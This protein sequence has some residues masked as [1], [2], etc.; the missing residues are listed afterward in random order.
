MSKYASLDAVR[1]DVEG[2]V[3]GEHGLASLKNTLQQR[4]K[5]FP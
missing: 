5:I 4:L 2:P 1:L 3:L